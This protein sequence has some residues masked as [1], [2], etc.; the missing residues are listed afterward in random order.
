MFYKY[1]TQTYLN[2]VFFLQNTATINFYSFVLWYMCLVVN[3]IIEF[4]NWIKSMGSKFSSLTLA[5][6]LYFYFNMVKLLWLIFPRATYLPTCS[7]EKENMTVR[8]TSINDLMSQANMF[9]SKGG[10]AQSVLLKGCNFS[11]TAGAEHQRA[12]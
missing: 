6:Y 10:G 8:P 2:Y 3:N 5:C 9:Y 7:K 1:I 4:S 12:K 11:A